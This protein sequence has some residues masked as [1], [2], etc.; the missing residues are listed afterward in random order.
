MAQTGDPTAGPHEIGELGALGGLHLV[1]DGAAGGL[2]A[3]AD[4]VD[5][6]RRVQGLDIHGGHVGTH[7]RELQ[8]LVGRQGQDLLDPPGG[9]FDQERVD[10]CRRAESELG[11]ERI[12]AVVTL[13]AVDLPDLMD[14]AGRQG[15]TR[16]DGRDARGLADQIDVQEVVSGRLVVA[17]ET[18]GVAVVPVGQVYVQ[19]SVAVVVGPAGRGA[20][21]FVVGQEHIGHLYKEPA[22]GLAAV[23]A[24]VTVEPAVLGHDAIV[25]VDHM[26][27]QVT[28]VVVVDPGAV[29]AVA[30]VVH[31][32]VGRDV[33]KDTG[34]VAVKT[35]RLRVVGDVKVEVAVV[36]EVAPGG[37]TAEA[38]AVEAGRHGHV[39]EHATQIVGIAGVLGIVAQQQ[40]RSV[41]IDDEE[42]LIAVVVVVGPDG[43]LAV[44]GAAGR[45][46]D[47][48]VGEEP[49]TGT[50]GTL[51]VVAQQDVADRVGHVEIKITIAV[52]IDPRTGVG[53]AGGTENETVGHVD[54]EAVRI[55]G[56]A[57]RDRIVA[58]EMIG[59]LGIGQVEI[60]VAVVVVVAPDADAGN[61]AAADARAGGCDVH[62][63]PVPRTAAVLP[64]VAE[65]LVVAVVRH[66]EIQVA[67]VVEVGPGGSVTRGEVG[68]V[69]CGG[70][71]PLRE[72]ASRA[73]HQ[74][75]RHTPNGTGHNP[76]LSHLRILSSQ[77]HAGDITD[78]PVILLSAPRGGYLTG[79]ITILHS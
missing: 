46:H 40:I 52:V 22:V 56:P 15:Q 27:V 44:A 62:E 77:H 68:Q 17:H 21:G 67:I 5:R 61:L 54:E 72:G 64:I 55:L 43:A 70:V 14:A 51:A 30:R 71:A 53:A 31:Q 73:K 10:Q 58:E 37:T 65:E 18:V 11:G 28:V 48:H 59:A 25:E 63:Q 32:G 78:V 49:F 50:V 76:P 57:R 34:V 74:K 9:P 3:P 36:V 1:F 60:Q 2:V 75:H 8:P 12:L 69:G 41:V 20:I 6:T 45:G 16:P 38:G 7:F 42:I 33:H 23:G 19:V 47:G 26:E 66:I 29:A 24:V 79:I 39:D 35:I 13:A 4:G